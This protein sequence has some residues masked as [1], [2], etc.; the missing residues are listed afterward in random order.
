M[1]SEAIVRLFRTRD[2]EYKF[3]NNFC[4]KSKGKGPFGK[5]WISYCGK[6]AKVSK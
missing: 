2:R 6:N 5:P 1:E 3:T 4:H